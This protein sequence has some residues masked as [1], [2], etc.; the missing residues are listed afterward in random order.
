MTMSASSVQISWTP[1][2]APLPAMGAAARGDTAL[3]IVRRLLS[4]DDAQLGLLF[5][6]GGSNL[7]LIVG[8]QDELPWLDGVQYLGRAPGAP[9]LLLPTTLQPTVPESLLSRA[10]AHAHIKPPVAFMLD[11]RSLVSLAP[12]QRLSRRTLLAWRPDAA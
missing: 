10:I 7:I 5:G 6:V 12:A 4:R 3:K 8:P 2:R 9:E 1:R 11:E